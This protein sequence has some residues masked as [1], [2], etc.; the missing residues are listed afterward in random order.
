MKTSMNVQ[1]WT[2]ALRNLTRRPR[3]TVLSVTAI[4]LAALTM[5]LLYSL[6]AGLQ[7]D[8]G[9]NIQRYA[10]GQVIVEDDRTARATGR[11]LTLSL[12][13]ATALAS[14]LAAVAG[15]T[16][17]FP[18]I[19]S[20]ASVFVDGDAVYFPFLGLDLVGDPIKLSDFLPSGGRL[21]SVGARE[22]LVSTGLASK[23]GIHTGDTLTAVTQTLRGSSNGM[24]FTVTGI[25]HP[26]LGS[27][28]APWLFTDIGTARRFLKLG[29]GATNLLVTARP[30]TD[31]KALALSLDSAQVGGQSMVSARPWWEGS[32]IYGFIETIRW[33]Y[34]VIGLI[35]FVLAST[36]IVNTIL[37]VVLERAKEIGM[38]AALG[39]DFRQIR[40]LFLAES[41]W[42]G[43]FGALIGVILGSLLA[44]VLSQTGID[45]SQA[46]QG[47]DMDVNPVIRPVLE[48]WMPP[49][50]FVSAL[51]VT[52]G[53]TL[54]PIKRLRKMEIVEA[55]RGEI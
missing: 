2:L 29:D 53:F 12:F 17:V 6:I 40:G 19:T 39:M 43:A 1:I 8:M 24:T 54:W 18:R 30:G 7:A 28:Q 3:R 15:V 50:V 48:A 51:V 55:L 11:A 22:A 41:A 27:Y 52:V 14:R 32:A 45:Y 20:G 16:G 38:L 44:V 47:V 31:L 10:T 9:R 33:V 37:M 36:V 23:L 21:P 25:V 4:A 35:F 13:D 34:S 49:V 42:M 26:D 5:T 46:M